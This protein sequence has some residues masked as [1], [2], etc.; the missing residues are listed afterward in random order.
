MSLQD[1]PPKMQGPPVHHRIMEAAR[2]VALSAG[3][4][5]SMDFAKPPT[6][7]SEPLSTLEKRL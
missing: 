1:A 7:A 2:G 5:E 4:Q 6:T 3:K